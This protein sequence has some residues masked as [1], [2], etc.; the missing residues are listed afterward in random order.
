MARPVVDPVTRWRPIPSS[1]RS[2]A[3]VPAGSVLRI[4][5]C[6]HCCRCLWAAHLGTPGPTWSSARV[7]V[8]VRRMADVWS[9]LHCLVSRVTGWW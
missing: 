7:Q 9:A 4:M 1:S 6:R 2:S 5:M 8:V 3:T